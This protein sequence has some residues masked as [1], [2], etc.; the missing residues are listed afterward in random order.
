MSKRRAERM[1]ESMMAGR[2]AWAE[3]EGKTDISEKISISL[4]ISI[5]SSIGIICRAIYLHADDQWR[6][7]GAK[8]KE[9]QNK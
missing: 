8:K 1:D 3:A 5:Y 2:K 7:G 9:E 4:S 6:C